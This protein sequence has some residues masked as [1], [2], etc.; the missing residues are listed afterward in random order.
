MSRKMVDGLQLRLQCVVHEFGGTTW[1]LRTSIAGCSC[2]LTIGVCRLAIAIA[3]LH[4]PIV[5]LRWPRFSEQPV[6]RRSIWPGVTG[7]FISLQKFLMPSE[8]GI[9][10]VDIPGGADLKC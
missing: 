9:P 6:S 8:P 4:F 5:G 2:S 7:Y 1:G 10:P 3:G